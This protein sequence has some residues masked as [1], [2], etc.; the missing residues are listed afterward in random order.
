MQAEQYPPST[1]RKSM[2]NGSKW[3]NIGNQGKL[4]FI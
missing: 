2:K 1:F 3:A 4:I